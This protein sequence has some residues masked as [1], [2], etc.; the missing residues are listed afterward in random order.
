MGAGNALCLLGF[1]PRARSGNSLLAIDDNAAISSTDSTFSTSSSTTKSVVHLGH[2][3]D[4]IHPDTAAELRRRFDVGSADGQHFVYRIHQNADVL[5]HVLAVQTSMITT[6]VR[7]EI[8]VSLRPKRTARSITG[9]TAPRR[10]ITPRMKAGISG[11][12]V[13]VVYSRISLMARMPMA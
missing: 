6:Q 1:P 11:T 8:A 9:T 3:G 7:R 2:A 5:L 10:F 13:S 12:W 4:E